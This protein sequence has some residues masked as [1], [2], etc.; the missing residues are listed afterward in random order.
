M[1]SIFELD[2][3]RRTI[4]SGIVRRACGMPS[5]EAWASYRAIVGVPRVG[6]TGKQTL[7]ALESFLL[8]VIAQKLRYKHN[9]TLAMAYSA[10]IELINSDP[11]IVSRVGLLC[12]DRPIY[13]HELPDLIGSETG[14]YPTPGMLYEW[15]NLG[16]CP[17]YGKNKT[18]TAR[19]LA[20]LI[21]VARDKRERRRNFA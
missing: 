19:Q 21:G 14:Y 16:Y 18:Y 6:K 1:P 2:N 8:F 10:A 5:R 9:P 15:G 20:I 12:G 3:T 7:T 17:R 13:G 4:G 11:S